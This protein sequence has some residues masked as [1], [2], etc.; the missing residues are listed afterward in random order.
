MADRIKLK[1]GLPAIVFFFLIISGGIDSGVL[2]PF[3]SALLHEMG[4]ITVMALCGQKIESVKILPFGVDIR[5]KF[6]VTSYKTDIAVSSAGIVTNLLLILLALLL[7]SF[8][9]TENFIASNLLLIGVNILPIKTL[10]GGQILEK[11]TALFFGADTAEKVINISSLLF[12]I[13]LGTLGIWILFYSSFNFTLLILC[14]YLFC[15]I[16]LKSS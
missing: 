9:Q 3:L 4:H 5:K 16:F 15:G 2:I 8:K 1:I 12:V 6:C 13:L 14:A 7:P 11:T 10:D